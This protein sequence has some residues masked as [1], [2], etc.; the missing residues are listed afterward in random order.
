MAAYESALADYNAE[1]EIVNSDI[2]ESA[3]VVCAVRTDYISTIVLAIVKKI[4]A[5]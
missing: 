2:S 4:F 3:K 5:N 1:L